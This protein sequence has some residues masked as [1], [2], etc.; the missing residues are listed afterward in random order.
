MKRWFAG[1]LVVMMLVLSIPTAFASSYDWYGTSIGRVLSTNVSIRESP[2]ERSNRLFRGKNMDELCIVG[3]TGDWYIVDCYQSGLSS[4]EKYGY[5]LKRFVDVNG[6]EI[7]LSGESLDV[8]TDPWSGYCNGQ[9]AKSGEVLYVIYET[10]QWLVCQLKS[11]EKTP[12][13]CF[14]KKS[15]LGMGSSLYDDYTQSGYITVGGQEGTQWMVMYD[16]DGVS[17]GIRV[18][19]DLDTKMLEIIHSGDIVTVIRNDGEFAYVSYIRQNGQ[20]VR[21]WVK[22]KYFVTAN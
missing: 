1:F 3:D 16:H 17:V 4:E 5:V 11:E 15:D 21:G 9:K 20:E 22:T 10:E 6:Y 18:E 2:D 14:I 8:Y 12:G 19:P 7:V 13:S